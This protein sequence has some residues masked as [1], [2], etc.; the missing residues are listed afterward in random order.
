ML[1]QLAASRPVGRP[2]DV[3]V[4]SGAWRGGRRSLSPGV[5][6]IG[7]GANGLTSCR[8]IYDLLLPTATSAAAA[9]A[10]CRMQDAIVSSLT[11]GCGCK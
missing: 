2:G 1:L 6:P 9:A 4:A 8:R 5:L 7:A 11:G 10:I 3:S